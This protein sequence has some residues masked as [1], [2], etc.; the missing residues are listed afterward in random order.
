[1]TFLPLFCE[2]T[3]V[4]IYTKHGKRLIKESITVDNDCYV[5]R[6]VI[7]IRALVEGRT[8]PQSLYV[9]DLLA[10][11]GKREIQDVISANR[12]Q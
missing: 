4:A 3:D 10:D 5:G 9:S 7:K 8:G 2:W 12:R 11:N 1:V 6:K